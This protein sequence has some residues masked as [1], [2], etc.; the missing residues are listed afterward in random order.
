MC[1]LLHSM[2]KS[3]RERQKSPQ[4]EGFEPPHVHVSMTAHVTVLVFVVVVVSRL[5]VMSVIIWMVGCVY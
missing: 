2:L 4:Q 5:E 1:I 3:F